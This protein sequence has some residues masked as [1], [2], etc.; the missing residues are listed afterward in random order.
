[1]T[2]TSLWQVRDCH[3]VAQPEAAHRFSCNVTAGASILRNTVGAGRKNATALAVPL[4]PHREP[5][6][7]LLRRIDLLRVVD[8]HRCVVLC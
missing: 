3:Y 1:V 6:A 5:S 8:N 2:A 4:T 7:Q